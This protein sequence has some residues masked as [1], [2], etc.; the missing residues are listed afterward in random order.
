MRSAKV[1]L[2]RVN[3]EQREVEPEMAL[4]KLVTLLNLKPEQIAI[5]VNKKVVR[6]ANWEAT[7]LRED[8]QIE[9]VHFVGGG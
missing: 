1:L 9:I 5:E 2:I 6:R 3:G 8:D 7:V 4:P